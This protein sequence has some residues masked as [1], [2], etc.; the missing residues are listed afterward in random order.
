M[1]LNKLKLRT[2][3]GKPWTESL[4]RSYLH[5]H[6]L[7]TY[8]LKQ[9]PREHL[10]PKEVAR[11]LGIS[12]ESV[13]KLISKGILA[14]TQVTPCAP[15]HIPPA[16]LETETLKAAVAALRA[17]PCSRHSKQQ[18]ESLQSTDSLGVSIPSH[19]SGGA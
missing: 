12:V 19:T 13:R 6:G 1:T 10:L 7:P 2:G 18:K 4:V 11:Q 3:H 16:A 5:T 17:H 9:T 14:A 15:Y 8:R